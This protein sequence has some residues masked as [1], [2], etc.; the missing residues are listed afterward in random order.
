MFGIYF[1]IDLSTFPLLRLIVKTA[2]YIQVIFCG[3]WTCLFE[4][5]K[6][7]MDKIRNQD[8][9]KILHIMPVQ[10]YVQ[11]EQL[12]WFWKTNEAGMRSKN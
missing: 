2:N 4:K 5:A 1:H 9:S 6:T 8:L 12:S 11:E 3:K 10:K 7:R